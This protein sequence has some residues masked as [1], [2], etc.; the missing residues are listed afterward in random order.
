M[1]AAAG[2]FVRLIW[3]SDPATN[4]TFGTFVGQ[5]LF[6]YAVVL[7]KPIMMAVVASRINITHLMANLLDGAL[8]WTFC[9]FFN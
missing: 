2:Y 8:K 6:E 3:L 5:F 1:T 4:L 7:T 9:L